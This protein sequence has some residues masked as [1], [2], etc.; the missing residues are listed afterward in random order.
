LKAHLSSHRA[1]D[2]T[3]ISEENETVKEELEEGKDK[4][5]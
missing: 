1:G 4:A 3:A 5:A 2:L